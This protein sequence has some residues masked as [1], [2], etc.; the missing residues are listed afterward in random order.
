ML[1][2][3]LNMKKY[4]ENDEQWEQCLLSE[5]VCTKGE[6]RICTV[7]LSIKCY[8]FNKMEI[9]TVI[10]NSSRHSMKNA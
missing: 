3:F 1:K 4:I 10:H 8:T 2:I 9:L 7:W 5:L 6:H